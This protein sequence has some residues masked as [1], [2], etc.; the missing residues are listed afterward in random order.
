M[1][2]EKNWDGHPVVEFKQD[3]DDRFPFSF[4]VRKAKLILEHIIE[5]EKFVEENKNK[6]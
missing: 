1:I 3:E 5:I 4:G 2:E 6:T